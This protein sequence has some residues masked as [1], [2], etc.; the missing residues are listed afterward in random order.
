M[1]NNI[2]KLW[3]FY[4]NPMIHESASYIVSYHRTKKG[5]TLA[6][7]LHKQQ[8]KEEWQEM[9]DHHKKWCEE[10]GVKYRQISKFGSFEDWFVKRL[11]LN[12]LP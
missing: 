4:Y 11:E 2:L 10:E 3:A 8:E 12:I 1:E 6:M 7:N 5:A 9:N